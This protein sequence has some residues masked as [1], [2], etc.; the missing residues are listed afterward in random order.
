MNLPNLVNTYSV[1]VLPNPSNTL[2][3][4]IQVYSSVATNI[5]TN[6]HVMTTEAKASID[7]LKAYLA[8]TILPEPKSYKVALLIQME[9]LNAKG[10]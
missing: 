1:N 7:K 3:L 8:N 10:V 2:Q 9:S 6:K 5:I 4:T